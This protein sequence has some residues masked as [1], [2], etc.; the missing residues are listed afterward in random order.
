MMAPSASAADTT[1]GFRPPPRPARNSNRLEVHGLAALGVGLRVEG[2]LV[3]FVQRV[4]AGGFDGGCVHEHVLAAAF[5]SD[6]A[7]AFCG[8]EEFHGADGH[9]L[10][11]EVM[12]FP[13]ARDARTD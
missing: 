1:A 7:E 3:A 11:P 4:H 10:F 9:C 8:I 13:R 5:R 6:E 2:D 12:D